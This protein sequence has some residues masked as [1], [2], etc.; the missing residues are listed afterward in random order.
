[1]RGREPRRRDVLKAAGAAAAGLSAATLAGCASTAPA[2][3]GPSAPPSTRSR[4]A[5]ATRAPAAGDAMRRADALL[6]QMTIEEKAMQLSSIFPVGLFGPD[7]PI[8]SQLDAELKYGIG[9]VAAL[10]LIGH[11][12]PEHV[13]KSVNAVQRYLITQTRLKIPRDLPQRG[14]ERRG[15]ASLHAVPHVD[16]ARGDVGPRGN[17]GDGRPHPAS[18]AGGG[19]APGA[20]TRSGRGPRCPLGEG[21]RDL[22][23][24]SLPRERH[25]RRLHARTARQGPDQGRAGD[26]EALRRL[27]GDRR[28]PEHGGDRHRRAR[29]LRRPCPS[30]R[31]RVSARRPRV[32]NAELFGV[33]RRADLGVARHPHGHVA[34]PHGLHGDG[35]VRL[36]RRRLPAQPPEGCRNSRGGGVAR[37]RGRHG[38]RDAFRLRLRAGARQSRARREGVRVAPGP[39]RPPGAAR[40]VRPRPVREP[41][42]SRE[43]GRDTQSRSR[44]RR[45]FTAAR[46]R[47]GDPAQ[48]REGSP[49]PQPRHHEDRHHRT[50]RRRCG[51]RLHD[52]HVCQRAE[53]ES[54]PGDRWRHRDGRGR[55]RR[56]PRR[57]RRKPRSR[58]RWRRCSR[59]IAGST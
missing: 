50:A 24:G 43:S 51:G 54:R 22:R 9:H 55:P 41:V 36:P 35:S 12:T 8:Q 17:A 3:A 27:R 2:G 1:M 47:I 13:A 56:L 16:R 53:D 32:G 57:P 28:R 31:G 30:L 19:P 48:E 49:A 7:G 5:S 14:D 23:R 25:G 39:L 34:R 58:P 46:R 11:K 29:A 20:V 33:R 42:C 59:P 37:P 10:G 40:Q 38:R 45:A 4:V 26:R 6:R 44:G 15:G 21:E 18:D 52:L